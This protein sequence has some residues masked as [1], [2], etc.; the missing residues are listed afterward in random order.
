MYRCCSALTNGT[1]K[2][3]A[4]IMIAS[5]SANTHASRVISRPKFHE[6]GV[7]FCSHDWMDVRKNSK[8]KPGAQH[9]HL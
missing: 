7:R 2:N 5:E 9:C 8:A 1:Q 3:M 6:S 4:P